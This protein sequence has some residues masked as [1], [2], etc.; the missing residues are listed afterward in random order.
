MRRIISRRSFRPLPP[1]RSSG[2]VAKRLRPSKK[3]QV[4]VLKCPNHTTFIQVNSLSHT[5]HFLFTIFN[6]IMCADD[7]DNDD[8]NV[9]DDKWM[10]ILCA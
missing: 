5:H 1:E 10:N 6:Y 8:D 2:R 9:D 4:H 3:T 7:A